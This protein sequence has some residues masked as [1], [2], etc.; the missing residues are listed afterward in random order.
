MTTIDP[1]HSSTI[2]NPTASSI[3]FN[4]DPRSTVT[5]FNLMNILKLIVSTLPGLH[6]ITVRSILNLQMLT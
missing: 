5:L 3:S 1:N 4:M 6:H 2:Q